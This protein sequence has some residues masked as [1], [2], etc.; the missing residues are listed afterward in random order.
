MVINVGGL[1]SNFCVEFSVNNIAD[2]YAGEFRIKQMGVELNYVP[3][4]S[5]GIPIPGGA[6]VPVQRGGRGRAAEG[7]APCGH[8]HHRR[9]TG[10]VRPGKAAARRQA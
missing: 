7:A 10:A 6:E 8:Q 5:R 9:D 1:A 3:E 2:F 4:I